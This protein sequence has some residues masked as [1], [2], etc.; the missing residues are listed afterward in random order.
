MSAA[1]APQVKAE[2]M[3]VSD[4][5]HRD[6]STP[7]KNAQNNN[8]KSG[9]PTAEQTP[10]SFLA[11]C[12]KLDLEPNPFE[13]S[14]SGMSPGGRNPQGTTPGKTML[15][16]IAAMASPSGNG[17]QYPGWDSSLRSGPLSPAMLPGPQTANYDPNFRTG[18]TPLVQGAFPTTPS[19]TAAIMAMV[20]S[21]AGPFV[22]N[23]VGA[24]VPNGFI[25]V[26]GGNNMNDRNDNNAHGGFDPNDPA[27]AAASGLYLLSQAHDEIAKRDEAAAQAA[28]MANARGGNKQIK[29]EEQSKPTPTRRPSRKKK[30]PS[31]SEDEDDEDDEE[32]QKGPPAK[33]QNTGSKKAGSVKSNEGAPETE[34][35][36]RRNFLE[37]NRQAALK[38]R[39]RKKQWL[40]NLETK[41][42]FLTSDN[43]ALQ[44]QATALREEIINLKTLLLAHKDCPIAQANGVV[45]PGQN[46]VPRTIGTAVAGLSSQSQAAQQQAQAALQAHA[47]YQQQQ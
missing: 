13:Q 29:Q 41:V 25:Q 47:N 27:A 15:P 45:I 10:M 38:C 21:E 26:P 46:G 19:T 23:T 40:K 4:G 22:S 7:D 43:E 18:L 44:N 5:N 17:Q 11:A 37:R 6:N 42:E 8:V 33:R 36:K 14:F 16:P 28:A 20:S 2:H 32:D 3:P 30:A 24:P 1:V 31:P 35:E 39:Q 12:S 34:E 9:L